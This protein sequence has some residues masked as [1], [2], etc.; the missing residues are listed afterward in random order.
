MERSVRYC[1]DCGWRIHDAEHEDPSALMIEHAI[2]TGHN[3]DST[4]EPENGSP[5]SLDE[6][7]SFR[8]RRR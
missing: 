7:Q 1:L 3:L 2:E 8:H 6:G 4:T 5:R